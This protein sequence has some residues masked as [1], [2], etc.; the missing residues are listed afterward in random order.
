M[1]QSKTLYSLLSGRVWGRGRW[2]LFLLLFTLPSLAKNQGA[3]LSDLLLSYMKVEDVHPDS[4]ERNI[5]KL[6]QRRME[7]A[8]A[9]ERAVYAAA[10]ARLYAERVSWRS[11]GTDLRDSMITWYGL[12]L[13]D[14]QVLAQTKA[15]RWKPFVV[16]GK[17]EGYFRGDM[18]N[19]VWR[20]MV[21]R[22]YKHVRDTSQVLPKYGEMI[23]FYK[24]QGLREGALL[25]A[26]D[27]LGEKE[28][29]ITETDLVRLRDEYAD[30]PL[31]AEVYLRLGT[32]TK[33]LPGWRENSA[34]EID[35]ANQSAQRCRKWLQEGLQ[36][37]PKYKRRAALQNALTELSDPF[38]EK[39]MPTC[40]SPGKQYWW[41]FK[42]RNVQ[43][44]IID[45]KEHVFPAHDPIETFCDSILWTSPKIGSYKFTF[46][47]RTKAKL[48]EKIKPLE[49][50]IKVTALQD[51]FQVMPDSSARVLVVDPETG[52]P[53]PNVT[54]TAYKPTGDFK[55]TVSYF[56]GRTG[57]DGKVRVPKYEGDGKNRRGS[58]QLTYKICSPDTADWILTTHYFYNVGHWTGKPTKS[59]LR[60]EL[61]TDRAL[62]RPGQTIHVS[63]LAYT[64]LDWDAESAGEGKHTLRFY[65]SN[66]KLVEER[67]VDAND[68]GVFS[69][70]FV[71]P[72]GGRNGMFSIEADKQERIYFRVEEYKR[73]TFE[74]VL[75]DSLYVQGDSCEVRGVAKNY[76][77]SPLRGA[78][79]TGTYNWRTPWIYY[80][81]RYPQSEAIQLDTIET[82][83]KGRFNY[84]FKIQNSNIE[85][86][87]SLSVNVDVLS[88]QGETHNAQHWYWR[89]RETKSQPEP[90]K[91]D[92]TFLV[93]CVVDT[94]AVDKPGRIEVTTNLR[95]VCLF[96]T[97]S[98]AGRIW[99]DEMV[100]LSN[101]TFGIDI[102]Y[103]EEYDQSLTASFCFVKEGHIY[104]DTK[105]IYLM[106]PDNRL[107]LHW[108]TFRDLVQPGQQ[109]EWRLTLRRPDGTP[110]DANLM[111]TMY[112]ASLDY[113]TRH[114]WYFDI[115]RGHRTFSIPFRAVQRISLGTLNS[116]GW[117]NQKTKKERAISLTEI[118]SGLFQVGAYTRASG[119]AP[120]MYKALSANTMAMK[121]Y[122]TDETTEAL[123]GRIAGLDV[124]ASSADMGSNAN[125]RIRGT[126]LHEAVVPMTEEA[127]Q[128]GEEVLSVPMRENFNETAF[129]Y[130]QLR[131]DKDGQVS[132]AFTLPESL[133]RWNLLGVAHTQDM[134]YANLSE[135]IEAR[136]DLMAQ[137]YLPRFLRPG[138][139]AVLTASIRNVSDQQQKGKGV[140]QI[141][142]ARTEK[143]LKQ[144]K[145]S[146]D[147]NAQKD[148]VLHFMY[149]I[150]DSKHEIQDASDLVIRWMVEGSS[151]SDGE[152]RLLP[153]LPA[154]M[155][156]TNTVAIT[157][158]DPGV[159]N[160]DLSKIF[161]DGV[162]NRQ[163]TV[164]YTTHP[165]QYALQALPALARAKHNDVLSLASAYYAGVLGKTLGA[166]MPDSTEVYLEKLKA[167]QDADGG[168]RWY[169][170]MP[171]SP[172]LTR[173]VS[174]LLT[175]LNMLTGKKPAVQVNTQAVHYLLAQR[176]DS[177]YLSIADLRNLYIAQYS[178]VQ[179]SKEEQ[180]KVNFLMKLAK[181]D[182]I[183]EEGYERL[184]LLTIVL[185]QGDANRKAQKC[186][187]QFRKYIV[188][189]PDRGSYI[190]FPKGSFTSVDRKLHIHVQLME[191]L[192]R[193]NPQDTLLRGM[194]RYL[195][196]QKRTQEWSTP[197]NSANAVFALLGNSRFPIPNS[198]LK[199]VLTLTRQHSKQKNFVAE[200]DTLGYVRDSLLI[201]EGKL[202]VK[203]R[204]QKSS[205]GESWGA[206]YADFEQPFSQVQA[207]SVGLNITQEYPEKAKTGSRY[208]VRYRISADRDYEYVTLIV[209]RPAFTEPVDQRSGY[210]WGGGLGYYRQV[211]DATTEF[212]FCQ[213]PRGD[214]LIEE[215]LYVER[216]GKYHSGVAV[217]RCEYAEEFQGHSEDKVVDVK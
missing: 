4:L 29:R 77:G 163:L 174:Y 130:P 136:K 40:V 153:V 196:Q 151:C 164:E 195:L 116:G 209:P 44:V 23:A 84:K 169:P 66:H 5:D 73:P 152:Q 55:D 56:V 62:Y 121:E 207:H 85:Q 199:D 120:V 124:A 1:N 74:V 69:A 83:D 145:T 97:L 49:H 99:K 189:S 75:D 89:I 203:L 20:S 79:V 67:I 140:M 93:R 114:Q 88:Q 8:D 159:T 48:T 214:Y 78:R 119:R 6:K 127:G 204:L 42:V 208:T 156:V 180:K 200:D 92:S 95:D 183:E 87:R 7:S 17:D 11:V 146:F 51:I 15:K 143:V 27:S 192:Q 33:D 102:P 141:M 126:T 181:R 50:W 10:I 133:T 211:H 68:M 46:V 91:I 154:T 22:I 179:L 65:D 108:D 60:T 86:R 53:Q 165:E 176:I 109:E 216:D 212:S 132:I 172:Y 21:E 194:C 112:D 96:Y 43:S 70:D 110:A 118:N 170:S 61:F 210:R 142:D 188:S 115:G 134:M 177:T 39:N 149:S 76:D 125:V 52:K 16:V 94:F 47:P 173:E 9:A 100:Q 35:E 28:E 80:A 30:V 71:I 137:L 113:F 54:I 45:G 197:V 158:Y 31:C 26:L 24:Q 168:F 107:Q 155:H 213:M 18:L 147:L 198:P 63:G 150:Q 215:T 19:V 135:Q 72:T 104:T 123:Q 117:Y 201:E 129:F 34:S 186:L 185:K 167:L 90:V 166:N 139:E 184:A 103:R 175:R 3:E 37:Y 131:T 32:M 193:M 161:P 12:A 81:K 191:A 2:L 217:I 206:V 106:Q 157:A 58:N 25:L 205:K 13:A 148:T 101:E 202:P 190:E 171:T 64:R 82:D 36:K 182:D 122:A 59:D 160:F 105:T 187:K 178:G 144:W 128:E 162:T 138:D 38:F 41:R 111:L 14:K 57:L 98:A